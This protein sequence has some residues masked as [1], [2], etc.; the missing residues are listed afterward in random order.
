MIGVVI[1]GKEESERAVIWCEELASMT[2]LD[3]RADLKET[4]QWPKAG[5]LVELE[6]EQIGETRHARQVCM[7]PL[8][9][10]EETQSPR[11]LR[12][13]YNP[14]CSSLTFPVCNYLSPPCKTRC[15]SL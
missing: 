3:S 15:G 13:P 9:D 10:T 6:Y 2:Y 7:V 4:S 5:D 12:C 11:E 1:W 14:E 8:D